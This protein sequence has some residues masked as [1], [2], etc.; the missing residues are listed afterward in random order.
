MAVHNWA[1]LII[2]N[3]AILT[4]IGMIVLGLWQNHRDCQE[5]EA[6]AESS[7]PAESNQEGEPGLSLQQLA[8]RVD[9]LEKQREADP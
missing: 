8:R 3:T 2:P 1:L 5:N 7:D 4:I 6:L 9:R